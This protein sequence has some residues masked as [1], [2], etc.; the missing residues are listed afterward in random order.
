[1]ETNDEVSSGGQKG[2][3][4]ASFGSVYRRLEHIVRQLQSEPMVWLTDISTA[5]VKTAQMKIL[6]IMRC[7]VDHL[8]P[9]FPLT[10]NKR[11]GCFTSR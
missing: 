11:N 5:Q 7:Y 3:P 6:F 10:P 9:M 8:Q 1:M 2:Y 4:S